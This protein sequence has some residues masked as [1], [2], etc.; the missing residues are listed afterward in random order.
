MFSILTPTY[1][2]AHTLERVY[3]SLMSQT[4][5]D[6]EWHIIDD[7][8]TDETVS[9]VETWLKK[10]LPFKINYHILKVNKGKPNALN[11]GLK[12]CSRPITIIAD[13]DDTFVANTIYDLKKLWETVN[14]SENANK[15][16]S[17]W[18]LVYN[19]EH[20]LVGEQFPSN[21]WQ[22][23]LEKRILK[24]KKPITGEKWHSW[25]TDVLKEF[26]M[27]HSDHSFISEG[28]TWNRINKEYDF[29]C[30]NIFHRIY[31]ASPDGLILKK[32]SRL[33]IEK[34]K[35]YGSY[36]QLKGTSIKDIFTNKYYHYLAFNYVKS[37][38]IYKNRDI[39]LEPY[40]VFCCFLIFIWLTPVRLKSYLLRINNNV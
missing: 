25:R 27:Y 31:Y 38:M 14:L 7:A 36:Y 19:E 9:L 13:S 8:S 4:D 17:I 40:K 10:D 12:F 24:R 39:T 28:T 33:R 29:L 20:E 23:N 2:R 1:N 6:F 30:V 16:A 26:E 11:V 15:I 22:V 5:K 18:T 37:S 21:F 32:K 34:I 35:F 3:Q